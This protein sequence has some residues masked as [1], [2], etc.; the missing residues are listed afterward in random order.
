MSLRC[1]P[2]SE[3]QRGD[4]PSYL[5]SRLVPGC[6]RV[7][8]PPGPP[9]PGRAQPGPAPSPGRARPQLNVTGGL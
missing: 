4:E 9:G 5:F 1:P 8:S 2:C 3:G 6:H 7:E